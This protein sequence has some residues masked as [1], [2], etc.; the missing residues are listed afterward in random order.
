[1]LASLRRD[2][3]AQASPERALASQRYFKTGPGQ[4]GEGDKFLGLTVPQT[5]SFLPR[6]DALAEADI[7]TLLHSEWHEER[8]LALLALVRRFEKARRDEAARQR[9]VTLYLANTRW[10][11]NW[12][13]VDTSAPQILGGW[14]LDRDRS[15]LGKLARSP[16]LWER[17]IAV[18]ATLNFIRAGQFNDTLDLCRQLLSDRHDLVHKACGW[19]LREVG[20]RDESALIG[21]LDVH[22]AELPRTMLRYAIEKLSPARRQHYMR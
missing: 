2:F 7:V 15:L 14:L 10:I 19:M 8:L 17:R 3:H 16:G 12:D 13:L 5:R 1:M 11:N 9:I 22:A 18:L 6:T 20:N 4:Y 21:F